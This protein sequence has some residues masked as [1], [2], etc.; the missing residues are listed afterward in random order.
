MTKSDS[1]PKKLFVVGLVGGI[2]SGKSQVAAMFT[3]LGAAVI[4]ADR[5]GH[6]VL[7]RPLV[8]RQLSQQLGPSILDDRGSI[9]RSELGKLVFGPSAESTARLK[10]LEAVVH[11]QIHAE[12]VRQ[13]KQLQ[14]R[15]PPPAAIVIDAPLLLE[16][17]WA[18][19]CD[20]I[21]FVDTPIDIRRAR[22]AQRGWDAEQFNQRE[23]SQWSLDSKRRAATHI[24]DGTADDTQLRSTISRLLHEMHAQ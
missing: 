20:L 1:Q 3:A 10:K 4:D 21:L 2:A 12:A 24:I 5:L 8:A 14:E 17:D 6:D 11:P 16:A 13:L 15:I 18:P 7:Q 22:A 23:Q 19:L 9:N